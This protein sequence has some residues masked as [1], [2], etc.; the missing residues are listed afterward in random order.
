VHPLFLPESL[1]FCKSKS[2]GPRARISLLAPKKLSPASAAWAVVQS[3]P[4]IRLKF[5]AFGPMARHGIHDERC[6]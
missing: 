4:S 6:G 1:D 2:V 5:Y 3:Q